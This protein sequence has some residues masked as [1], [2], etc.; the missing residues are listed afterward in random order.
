MTRAI[1][2]A[3]ILVLVVSTVC[4]G[5]DNPG[6]KVAIHVK[7]H[8][9]RQTCETLPAISDSS[10][11][12]TTYAGS[13][14]D[15]FP[16]F[17]NLTEYLG[18]EYG[19]TWPDWTYTCAFTSCSDLVI[20]EIESPGDGISHAWSD[21]ETGAVAIPGWGWLYADSAGMVCII[22]HPDADAIYVLDC[23]EGLDEP[24]DNFCAGVYGATGDD[25]T[26]RSGGDDPPE[27]GGKSGGIRGYYKP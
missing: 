22:D 16:V 11:I 15:F 27:G 25:P 7:A 1:I 20:G 3:A 4:L 5:G 14:F 18:V 2:R 23:D 17:F 6:A 26:S 8:V 24:I 10:D 9:A 21:C 12:V 19:V 13:S